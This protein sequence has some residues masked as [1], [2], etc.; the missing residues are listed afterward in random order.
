MAE[1]KNINPLAD[2]QN[3][4][5]DRDIPDW[6]R[7]A[8]WED[9]SGTFDESK[10]VFDDL[11]GE[12]NIVP[13]E[14]PAWLEEAAPE[15][16]SFNTDSH[17][18]LEDPASDD[19]VQALLDDDLIAAPFDD[20]IPEEKTSPDNLQTEAPSVT[21]GEPEPDVPSWLKNLKLDEDSQETAVAWLEN[22]P[23]S[24]RATE[25]ELEASRRKESEIKGEPDGVL[26]W[27]DDFAPEE[28]SEQDLA[29][30]S[31]D[32]VAAD[33]IP[34]R[35]VEDKLFATEELRSF[36]D[37][38]P[39]WLNEFE[40]VSADQDLPP[41]ENDPAAADEAD[42]RFSSREESAEGVNLMPDWLADLGE[43]E[44]TTES[45]TQAREADEVSTPSARGEDTPDWLSEFEPPEPESEPE[46][47]PSSLA[48]LESLAENQVAPEEELKTSQEEREQTLPSAEEFAPAEEITSPQK[49]SPTDDTL[50]TEIPEWLSSLGDTESD[51][52]AAE[53]DADRN[54]LDDSASWLA[55]LEEQPTGELHQE[56]SALNSEVVEWLEGRQDQDQDSSALEDLRGSFSA[57][58][59]EPPAPT[60]LETEKYLRR[61][62]SETLPDWLSE[63]D[64]SEDEESSLEDT[65]KHA[66]H[67]LSEEEQNFLSQV[68]ETKEDNADWLSKLDL[69]DDQVGTESKTPP[70]QIDALDERSKELESSPAEEISISGGILDRLKD[71]GTISEK[72]E[73]PQWLE[74]LKKEE[75]PQET[76]ILWLKQFVEQGDRANLNDEIK[77]YT[78]ELNPGDS[79]PE[80]MEDL[81]NEE[82]PQTTAMLWLEKLSGER[83]AP[84]KTH[85]KPSEPDESDWLTA[86]EREEAEQSQSVAEQPSEDFIDS[87]N[88][89][90]ADLEIDEKIKTE[91]E[92]L[93]DWVE[94]SS[95]ESGTEGEGDTPPWMKA[96]SP[97]EGEFHTDELAGKEKEVEIPDWLA[98]YGDE[99][100]P[101]DSKGAAPSEP[102]TQDQE[103]YTWVPT[104]ETPKPSKTPIDLNTA[105]ISQLEGILGVSYQVARGIVRYREQHG[106][107][108]ELSDL[109]NVP[110]ISDEQTIEILKP[111]VIIK[112][113]KTA[114]KAVKPESPKK[115]LDPETR[116]TAA[117]SLLTDRKISQA[118]SEYDFLIKKKKRLLEVIN[119]LNIAAADHP[120]D[121]AIMK[122]LG[123]AYMKT[124]NLEAALE[125]YTR[126]EN[127]LQ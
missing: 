58:G 90:L 40:D 112:E 94:K 125:A 1:D 33:L 34:E 119:D 96:T 67:P 111:E 99:E 31:E 35:G 110:E 11:E 80:W 44:E 62:E 15:G 85:P 5:S 69:V 104:S 55:Q 10:P 38:S 14:I 54:D 115:D 61:E 49:V 87:S 42:I 59:D 57:I 37:D 19:S 47:D 127:L 95:P 84:Q 81:K 83:Q 91:G 63:L 121:V 25:E 107:Y 88:G 56:D 65:L 97:L 60:V 36:K 76:A 68:E 20:K 28:S 29:E 78:D 30:L 53:P 13:A 7:D 93:P 12:E 17:S 72:P 77:R 27:M 106:P 32:L 66:D 108:R 39:D 120:L 16:F 117:R 43:P 45:P 6:M 114:P 71:T 126:A 101:Q 51:K 64:T 24:L 26:G 70:I 122:T 9:D 46:S 109:F 86:L 89:W 105:A 92:E 103:E 82:D 50:N 22:M 124:D 8:G 116:L 4:N 23:E 79:V 73:V 48:W 102:A 18:A 123:D 52:S 21:P 98:G 113:V 41:Q 2:D 75:D 3:S 100:L 118:L 74:N